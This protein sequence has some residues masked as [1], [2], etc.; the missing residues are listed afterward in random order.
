MEFRL[1][2]FFKII[3]DC[4]FYVVNLGFYKILFLTTP[5]L[6]GW[7]E[8]QTMVFVS[9]YLLVDALHMTVFALSLIHISEPTRPY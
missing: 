8:D 3:M 4:M 6:A 7:S 1:D 9:S 2:F 5:I